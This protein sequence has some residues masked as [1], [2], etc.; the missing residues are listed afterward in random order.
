[1]PRS[2]PRRDPGERPTVRVPIAAPRRET[3][4]A[5]RSALRGVHGVRVEGARVGGRV[6]RRLPSSANEPSQEQTPQMSDA[7]K[8]TL[9]VT[10]NRTGKTYE[11]PIDGR[12]DPR[13]GP[14]PD[15]GRRRR[16][17]AAGLRPG[18]QEHRVVPLARSPSSTAPTGILRY[19]GYPIEQLAE[20]LELPRGGLPADPRRAADQSAARGVGATRSR[21]TPSSTRTSRRSS[22]GSTTTPTR[23]G[24]WSSTVGAL[25]DV[26][27]RGQGLARRGQPAQADRPA[28]RQ[29]PD[30]RRVRLP[31]LD[32]DALRLPRQR[33]Q[34]RR[35]LP[36]HDVQDH[37]AEVRA[38]PGP[39]RGDGHAAHPARRPRAE[40]LGHDHARDR[41]LRRRPLLGRGGRDAPRSTAPSTAAPTRP[42]CACSRRSARSTTSPTPSRRSRT[43]SAA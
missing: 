28:D 17:R 19:R 25:V 4:P 11:L 37:R 38:E 16:L 8:D 42:C 18:V 33:P 24:C 39:G 23:W 36:Q 35:Q 6:F 43:A 31:A 29:V 27:P 5:R 32:R 7:A 21:T 30:P 13:H 26:L 3:P 1:M 40:L 34:L 9:T 2:D 15:Q 20:K 10:D 14:A 22:T 12:R 41:L